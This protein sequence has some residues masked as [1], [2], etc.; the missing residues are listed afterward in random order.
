M[1]VDAVGGREGGEGGFE[2]VGVGFEPGEEGRFAEDAGVGEL[3]GVDVG[4]WELRED[5]RLRQL[6]VNMF[7][8]GSE[9]G[10]VACLSGIC[11]TAIYNKFQGFGKR[12]YTNNESCYI[13]LCRSNIRDLA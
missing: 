10:Q 12:A 11:E 4:I 7:M 9:V 1:A 6:R 2:G 13:F 8:E 3:G 5:V